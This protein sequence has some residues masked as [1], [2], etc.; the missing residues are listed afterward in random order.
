MYSF[1]DLKKYIHTMENNTNKEPMGMAGVEAVK[2]AGV[3]RV[4]KKVIIWSLVAV[5]VI[6]LAGGAV[7][8]YHTAQ[9]DKANEAIAKADVE[10]NDSI[11][12]VMYKQIADAGSTKSNE[13]AKLMVAINYYE[14]GKYNDAI[15]Y[16]DQA[17]VDSDIIEAGV[18]SLKGDCYANL[19][20]LDEALK[21]FN[22]AL[23]VADGNP[24]LVPFLMV[25]IANVY[26]AQKN[27]EKEYEIYLSLRTEYPNYLYDVDK[28]VE[29]AKIAA[30]K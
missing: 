30:G 24:A 25:K 4:N 28:Y 6:L 8:W 2:D 21:S 17:S 13:R 9:V 19:N 3:A 22:K 15:K 12:N 11:R 1:Y 7:Y 16:L 20:N 27:F 23:D 14:K 10:L 29:R 26:R 18:Y 5:A